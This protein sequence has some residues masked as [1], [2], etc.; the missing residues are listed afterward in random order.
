MGHNWKNRSHFAKRVTLENNKSHFAK[1][2]TLIKLVALRSTG[3][4]GQIG[5]HLAKWVKFG[6][7]GHTW[8]NGSHLKIIGHT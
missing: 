1:W 2:V 3:H 7:M 5:S 6:K 4:T 8:Q